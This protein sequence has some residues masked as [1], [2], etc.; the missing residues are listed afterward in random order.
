MTTVVLSRRRR[1]LLLLRQE[2]A[3]FA[4]FIYEND[5]FTNTGSGQT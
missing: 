4:P 3:S 5:H 1:E 2:N